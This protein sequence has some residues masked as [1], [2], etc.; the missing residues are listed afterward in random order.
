MVIGGAVYQTIYSGLKTWRNHEIN[1][2]RR[3]AYPKEKQQRDAA[4][5]EKQEEIRTGLPALPI[6]EP[7]RAKNVLTAV[8]DSRRKRRE[9]IRDEKSFI[10][11][12]RGWRT[13]WNRRYQTRFGEESPFTEPD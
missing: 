11:D 8:R 13:A 6:G 7:E 5:R 1:H 4:W 2:D 12:P 9:E 3:A 10:R